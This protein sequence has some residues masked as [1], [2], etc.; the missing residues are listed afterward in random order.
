MSNEQIEQNVDLVIHEVSAALQ[1]IDIGQVQ[2]LVTDIIRAKRVFVIGVGRV[3]LSLQAM[4]KRLNHIGVEAYYVGQ[5]DEP[6]V[7][8]D[9]LLIVASNSGESLIPLCITQ[10][11]ASLHVP[12]AY[13]GS[14][15]ESSVGK[16]A[17]TKVIIPVASKNNAQ[18]AI[19][20]RQP[21]TSLFEQVLLLMGDIVALSILQKKGIQIQD[22]WQ[23]HANL[24]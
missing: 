11:A 19:S 2:M 12:I 20:S 16:T 18:A 8:E 10:K 7:N 9:D 5:I 4:V 13:I 14:Q 3:L 22:T 15:P 6:A 21:M 1:S 17:G 23:Y 24:E